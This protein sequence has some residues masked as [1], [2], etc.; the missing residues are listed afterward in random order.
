MPGFSSILQWLKYNWYADTGRRSEAAQTM[1]WLL[2]QQQGEFGR[3]LAR[4][5]ASW[6]EAFSNHNLVAAR[7]HIQLAERLAPQKLGQHAKWKALSAVAALEGRKEE[8]R[9]FATQAISSLSAESV[10]PGMKRA[11]QDDLTDL[12]NRP[13]NTVA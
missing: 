13:S 6:F 7:E 12:L 3:W 1:Q 2:S 5:E 9:A 4:W 11:I 10:N 8:A